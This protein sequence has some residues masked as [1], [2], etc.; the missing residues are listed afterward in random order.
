M[1]RSSSRTLMVTNQNNAANNKNNIKNRKRY[2]R[3]RCPYKLTTQ[4]K[5]ANTLF[6]V[7][8]TRVVNIK[9][10]PLDPSVWVDNRRRFRL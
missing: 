10:R 7:W 3:R 8:T 2:P 6:G 5:F 4:A 1:S 9:L